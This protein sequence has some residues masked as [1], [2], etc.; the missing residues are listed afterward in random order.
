MTQELSNFSS[1]KLKFNGK[2]AEITLNRPKQRN[3]LTLS[4]IQELISVFNLVGESEAMGVLLRAEGQSFCSG[5]DFNDML[6]R[7]LAGMRQLMQTCAEMVQLIHTIPQFV[8]AS[9]N[10]LAVGA[11]CQLALSCD[12][13]VAAESAGFRTA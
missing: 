2:F 1:I 9:V 13:V 5:H 8:V 12:M 10:G 6:A 4:M 7:D 3:A 11:G